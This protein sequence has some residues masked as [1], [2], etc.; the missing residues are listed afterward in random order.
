M[1]NIVKYPTDDWLTTFT[2]FHHVFGLPI[3][4]PELLLSI[5]SNL[6]FLNVNHPNCRAQWPRGLRRR[7]AATRSSSRA[8]WPRGL[9]RRCA[10]T[11]SSSRAQ[12]PR[13]LRRRSAATRSSSRSQWPR[14]LRRRSAATR[15]LRLWVRDPQ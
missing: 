1:T 9:R 7:C 8:Q 5:F 10:A 13:G 3:T 11:R 2:V 12:W 4:S 6:L 14:G 15:L